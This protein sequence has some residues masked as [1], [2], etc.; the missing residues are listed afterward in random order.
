MN[1]FPQG[2]SG[3]FTLDPATFDLIRRSL[4]PSTVILASRTRSGLIEGVILKMK[5]LTLA[6]KQALAE[7]AA[8]P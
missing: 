1:V 5:P 3:R 8:R 2:I 4:H 6:V 7:Q